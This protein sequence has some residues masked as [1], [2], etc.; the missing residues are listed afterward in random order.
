MTTIPQEFLNK[1]NQLSLERRRNQDARQDRVT[2]NR[3]LA[4]LI[5]ELSEDIGE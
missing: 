5:A 2:H 1:L 3:V 4:D